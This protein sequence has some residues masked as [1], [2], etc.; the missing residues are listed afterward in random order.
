MLIKR[1]K[2]QKKFKSPICGF[3]IDVVRTKDFGIVKAD[4]IGITERHYHKKTTEVYHLLTGE[5][6]LEVKERGKKEKKIQ[7]ESGDVLVLQPYDIHKIIKASSRNELIV[8]C[9]PDWRE[10]DEITVE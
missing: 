5:L 6:T 4:N 10:D 9:V 3:L 2:Q 8:T 7:L 1:K